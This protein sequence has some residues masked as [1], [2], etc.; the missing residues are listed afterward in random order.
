MDKNIK[1]LIN[2]YEK[3]LHGNDKSIGLFNCYDTYY[4][5]C[6]DKDLER[7]EKLKDKLTK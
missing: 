5:G 6:W 3:V 7:I 2:L 4:K 1:K